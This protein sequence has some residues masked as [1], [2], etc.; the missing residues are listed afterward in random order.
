MD[1]GAPQQCIILGCIV[2][3]LNSYFELLNHWNFSKLISQMYFL[4]KFPFF[5]Q[6]QFLHV[7]GVLL[8]KTPPKEGVLD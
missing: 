3:F 2:F 5:A 6:N 8:T 4:L 1:L 7:L